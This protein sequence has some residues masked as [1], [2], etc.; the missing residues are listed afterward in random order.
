ML[1]CSQANA[2]ASYSSFTQMYKE[3]FNVK[4]LSEGNARCNLNDVLI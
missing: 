4:N 3:C 1:P 2:I